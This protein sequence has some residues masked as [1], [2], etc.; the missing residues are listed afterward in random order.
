MRKPNKQIANVYVN[1]EKKNGINEN[2]I[3]R[4]GASGRDGRRFK[5]TPFDWTSEPADEEKQSS[6]CCAALF[7]IEKGICSN[8]KNERRIFR[9]DDDEAPAAAADEFEKEVIKSSTASKIFFA[10]HF[11]PTQRRPI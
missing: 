9:A 2:K 11:L 8:S 5:C 6:V 4:W 7:A 1:V 10:T 3:R